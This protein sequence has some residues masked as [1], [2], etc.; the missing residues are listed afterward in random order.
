[1]VRRLLQ[2]PTKPLTLDNSIELQISKRIENAIAKLQMLERELLSQ[3]Q[4]IRSK[5]KTSLHSIQENLASNIRIV[6]NLVIL[7]KDIVIGEDGSKKINIH[8]I[9]KQLEG[10][11]RTACYFVQKEEKHNPDI[12][13]LFE[14]TLIEDLQQSAK[15]NYTESSAY[16]LVSRDELPADYECDDDDIQSTA[17]SML[18]SASSFIDSMDSRYRD[19]SRPKKPIETENVEKLI[20]S[21]STPQHQQPKRFCGTKDTR[22]SMEMPTFRKADRE[23]VKV[24]HLTSPDCFY[25]Q[26]LK[27]S[28]SLNKLSRNIDK[29]VRSNSIITVQI[30]EIKSLYLVRYMSDGVTHWCRGRVMEEL[31][32]Q[33]MFMVY[34]IDYGNTATV[35]R[36]DIAM[37]SSDLKQTIPLA[38]KCKFFD[39]YPA[40]GEWDP[41]AVYLMTKIIANN[42]LLMIVTEVSAE[43]L[44]VDLITTDCDTS[45]RDALKFL[46]YGIPYCKYPTDL[47]KIKK[48]LKNTESVKLYNKTEQYKKED[49]VNVIITYAINPY[50]IYVNMKNTKND[51]IKLHESMDSFYRENKKGYVFSPKEEMVVAVLYS[52]GISTSWRRGIITQSTEGRGVVTARLVDIG[53]V[54]SVPWDQIRKLDGRFIAQDCQAKLVKMT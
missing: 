49:S 43:I 21:T 48:Q 27:M 44:E 36:E 53:M 47:D 26:L 22:H 30:P 24:T 33:K 35:R 1:K 13:F 9:K 32:E 6:S 42:E 3:I 19:K 10:V 37:I 17:H 51:L 23:T 45:V 7:G 31:P 20:Q 12:E 41:K 8:M 52:D 54:I 38:I 5:D 16:S 29:H 40:K 15:L 2:K 34:F 4:S 14:D 39:L 11:N 50:N 18:S 46:G 25:V 28:G